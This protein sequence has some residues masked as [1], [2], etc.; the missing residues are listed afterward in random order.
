MPSLSLESVDP[1]AIGIVVRDGGATVPELLGWCL[2]R[3]G[4]V[5][6]D[7]S[8][9]TLV[10]TG[11][12]VASVQD[13]RND[14]APEA[15]DLERGSG[16]VGGKTIAMPND[17]VHVLLHAL[18]FVQTDDLEQNAGVAQLVRRTLV[19][20][21]QH[22]AMMQNDQGY[23]RPS[24]ATFRWL[25]L[26]SAAQAV[27]EEYRAELGVDPDLRA[28]DMN[29]DPSAVLSAWSKGLG[30]DVARYQ[31]HLDVA[32]LAYDV[33]TTSLVAWRSL[34][35]VAAWARL[36][37]DNDLLTDAVAG[38]PLWVRMAARRWGKFI[39]ALADVRPGTE[40][41][42]REELDAVVAELAEVLGAWLGDV[43]FVWHEER[44]QI[45]RWYFND[46]D[47]LTAFAQLQQ[48]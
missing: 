40:T 43:G 31:A 16:F 15:Y 24:N 35:Y 19:H 27:V 34:G 46:P 1:S 3:L 11:D 45:E 37:P 33:G 8:R 42:P 9:T 48:Q 41:M 26:T 18:Y 2:Q 23:R 10:V 14:D 28:G 21:A 4:Q 38:D 12:F 6:P 20:E 39:E 44:F 36:L 17:D 30:G 29:W 25:N 32:R 7:P 47:F 13:R 22:V 5:V